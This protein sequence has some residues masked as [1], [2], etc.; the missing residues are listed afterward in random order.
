MWDDLSMWLKDY[1]QNHP[2]AD[3]SKGSIVGNA[4]N[5]WGNQAGNWVN[6]QIRVP[7]SAPGE[8]KKYTTLDRRRD[9]NSLS[10]MFAEN[11]RMPILP[12][13]K[14]GTD[15]GDIQKYGKFNDQGQYIITVPESNRKPKVDPSWT[16]EKEDTYLAIN[17]DR[18]YTNNWLDTNRRKNNGR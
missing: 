13:E 15:F 14:Y 18:D 5:D 1:Y 17:A 10:V 3:R 7:S 4:L 11:P 12:K 6:D 9:P 16:Q 8:M 2:P